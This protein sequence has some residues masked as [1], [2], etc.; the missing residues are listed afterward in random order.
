MVLNNLANRSSV[1]FSQYP[2]FPWIL[3]KYQNNINLQ[4]KNS[5]RDLTKHIGE[6]ESSRY[7][8]LKVLFT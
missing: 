2:I 6:L 5:F 1:D 7:E 4:E 3:S 8:R